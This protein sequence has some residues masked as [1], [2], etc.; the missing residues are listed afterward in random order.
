MKKI[1][2][3]SLFFI[4]LYQADSQKTKIFLKGGINISK[5]SSDNPNNFYEVNS[6]TGFNAGMLAK[7]P[8]G[9][10]I[11]FQPALLL[12]SKGAK[13]KGGNPPYATSYFNAT[14]NPLYLELPVNIVFNLPLKEKSS[15]FFGAGFYAALGIGGKNKIDGMT[16]SAGA[17][18]SEKK[19]DFGSHEDTYPDFHQWAGIGYMHKEDFGLTATTGIHYKRLLF[20]VDYGWGLKNITKGTRVVKDI[21]KN[22]VLGLSIG[23]QIL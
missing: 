12:S 14:T 22:R 10:K 20:S 8:L 23:Y 15:L 18:S 16:A 21:N 19:I 11:V 3:T 4:L 17:F 6:L 2:T 9:K 13:T 1:F 5:F 7:L